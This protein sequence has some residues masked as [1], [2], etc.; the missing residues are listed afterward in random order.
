MVGSRQGQRFWRK[1]GLDVL[2]PTT[3]QI[4]RLRHRDHAPDSLAGNLV[5]SLVQA[6]DGTV[7][8]GTHSGLSR[9]IEGADG[10]I[11][12]SHPLRGKLGTQTAPTREMASLAATN[13]LAEALRQLA[14]QAPQPMQVAVSK[15]EAAW[16][17]PIS[18]A[19]AS[20]A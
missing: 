20:G 7:W 6:R 10:S 11:R 9:A 3:G 1:E 13:R 8:V 5:R 4:R 12:F 16:S 15:A 17:R 2:D 18:R 14:T 19:L